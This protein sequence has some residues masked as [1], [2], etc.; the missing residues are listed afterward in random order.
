MLN[1]RAEGV[2]LLDMDASAY[3]FVHG[4]RSTRTT[5]A[6]WNRRPWPV[7]G[8]WLAG[9]LLAAGGLL[10]AVWMIAAIAPG[11][12]PVSLHRPPLQVGQPVDATTFSL[13]AQAYVL[14]ISVA[15]VALAL[16][17]SPG[18]LLV[19][20]LPHALPELTALFLPLAAWIIASRKGDWDKLL[21]ATLVTVALAV[22]VLVMTALWEVYI[23]RHVLQTLIGY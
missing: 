4:L 13:S 9:S 2:D 5:L 19:A 20:L 17:T 10:L 1:L 11:G 22:P 21:A 14:G 15:N 23:A 6:A 8:A 7:L 18:L 3:A 16:H 12:G